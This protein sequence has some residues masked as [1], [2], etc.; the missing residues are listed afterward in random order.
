MGS[1]AVGLYWLLRVAADTSSPVSWLRWITPLGWA[2]ELRPFTG[3]R[4]LV[5]LLPA[6]ATALL[7]LLAA[8]IASR[9][10]VGTG[11]I[12]AHDSAEPR[13]WGLSSPAGLALRLERV[14]LM[15]WIASVGAFGIVMG[16]VSKSIS[17]A[18]ISKN[19]NRELA[20]LGSGSVLTPSGYLGFAFIFFVLAAA[21]FACAQIAAVRHEE[22][23][24]QLETLL[25]LPVGRRGWL[26]GRLVLAMAGVAA[27]A[28]S[29]SLFTW[30]GATSEGVSVS[31]ARMLEAGLNCLPVALVFLGLGALVYAVAPRAS[32]GVVYGLAAVAFLWYLTGTLL[33]APRW[34]VDLSPFQH[35]GLVPAQ[36]FRP[37]SALVM[38]AI[39]LAAG[40]AS[41]WAFQ[42]R[43]LA[44]A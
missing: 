36:S 12:A 5:L 6:A 43:D 33:G 32:T 34:L 8:R 26:G 16:V 7:L 44:G 17:S 3:P 13:L 23:G 10:D 37:V 39:G 18:G 29:A 38:V 30:L 24:G 42:R 20:R 19:L 40:L 14:S 15:V 1:A 9:R 25:A 4:P 21:L 31:L 11:L 27:I 2:E 22:S 41:L 35:V 28:A